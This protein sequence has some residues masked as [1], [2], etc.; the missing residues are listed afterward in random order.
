MTTP[1]QLEL[2]CEDITHHLK[3]LYGLKVE[4]KETSDI[5]GAISRGMDMAGFLGGLALPSSETFMHDFATTLGTTIYLPKSIREDPFI[6]LWVMTHETQH[7][8]QYLESGA[9][10]AWLYLTKSMDRAQY[11]S[12]AY[13]AGLAVQTWLTGTLPNTTNLE[14]VLSTLQ[15]GYHLRPMDALYARVALTSHIESILSGIRMTQAAR[16]VLSFLELKYPTLKGS[17]VMGPRG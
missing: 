14:S 10:L 6:K 7:V 8:L 12:D 16:E 11:E 5:M 4:D 2:A 13:S 17:V 15:A 3:T 1:T 9:T